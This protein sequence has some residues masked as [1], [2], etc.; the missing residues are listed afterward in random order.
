MVQR[1]G[2]EL[3]GRLASV[4]PM[5][6]QLAE[7]FNCAPAE[8]LSIM[9]VW[10]TQ[11]NTLPGD[12]STSMDG[13]FY[14]SVADV[15]TLWAAAESQSCDSSTTSYTTVADG[16]LE[17]SCVEHANCTSGATVVSCSWRG[18]HNWPSN[19][20]TNFGMEAV[21]EFFQANPRE[22]L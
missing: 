2:C 3:A 9:N 12:G 7:G 18:P 1:L 11:D 4:A 19:M 20:S 14:T 6:G 13:W 17:W 22:P 8:R 15:R 16:T 10:G 21:W 5:H